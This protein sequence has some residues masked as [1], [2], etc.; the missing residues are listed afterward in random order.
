[1]P[2]YSPAQNTFVRSQPQKQLVGHMPVADT[3]AL[4]STAPGTIASAARSLRTRVAALV[5]ALTAVAA[6]SACSPP[7]PGGVGA[8]AVAV[9]AQQA[10]KPYAWGAAGPYAFDCSG[11][12]MYVYGRLGYALPHNSNSQ[13]Y[14]VAHVS[15]GARQPGD[16]IMFG[17]PGAIYHVGIYAGNNLIWHA[18]SPG[19]VVSL[20][21]IW[22]SDYSVGRL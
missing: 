13:Y 6:V 21:P 5:L 15:Q 17:S 10:G 7:A 4:A 9:A 2:T 16:L 19:S 1:M 3:V 14:A 8:Q 22:T 11:L 18:A 12:T 20:A